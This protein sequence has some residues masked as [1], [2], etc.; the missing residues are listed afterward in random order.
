MIGDH[1]SG[2][3]EESL[4]N[5]IYE[6]AHGMLQ[7]ERWSD[8]ADILRAM[9]L[10]CPR[11][12]RAW[13]ALGLC[14]EEMAQADIALELYALGSLAAPSSIRC[15]LASARILRDRGLLTEADAA[16]D[17]AE[18]IA[19]QSQDDALSALVERERGAS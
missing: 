5:A 19:E 3:D 7:D 6:V 10:A 8:A 11:D 17:L 15:R 14:H 12:E 16:L 9:M 4:G 13:L 1:A 18:A 2:I